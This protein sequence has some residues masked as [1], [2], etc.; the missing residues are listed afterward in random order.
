MIDLIDLR[1]MITN[2]QYN[3]TFIFYFR[4]MRDFTEWFL[5]GLAILVFFAFIW[6]YVYFMYYLIT[7]GYYLDSVIVVCIT[8]CIWCGVRNMD[9]PFDDLLPY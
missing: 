4:E 7:N 3:Q 1:H 5:I 8:F 9:W 6:G 2:L